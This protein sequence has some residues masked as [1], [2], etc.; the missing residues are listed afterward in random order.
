[1]SDFGVQILPKPNS[2]E[3]ALVWTSEKDRL[4]RSLTRII[5]QNRK[6]KDPGNSVFFY[7]K[8][9]TVFTKVNYP[10]KSE[11]DQDFNIE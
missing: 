7:S 1:M 5:A 9:Y 4:C 6:R 2:N 10:A 3:S 11:I 8:S